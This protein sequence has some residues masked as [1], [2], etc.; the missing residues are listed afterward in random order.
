MMT[1]LDQIDACADIDLL[2][3]IRKH[4]HKRIIAYKDKNV[5]DKR[6][7]ISEWSLKQSSI[8][9]QYVKANFSLA[10]TIDTDKWAADIEKIHRIDGYPKDMIEYLLIWSQQDDF[11]KQQIRSGGSLRRH[12]E[13]LYVKAKSDFEKSKRGKVHKI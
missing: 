6:V 11:W 9:A 2:Y 10:K 13:K 8:L 12:L 7:V 1:I 4:A 5:I 3:K